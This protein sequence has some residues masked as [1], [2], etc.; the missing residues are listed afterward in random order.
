VVESK[1]VDPEAENPEATVE[2]KAAPKQTEA[3]PK[4]VDKPG[5]KT[6]IR[7]NK[8]KGGVKRK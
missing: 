7:K 5:E 4:E 2:V 1:T 8:K 3:R 6:V